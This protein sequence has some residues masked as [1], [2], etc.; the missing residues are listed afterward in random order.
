MTSVA[1]RPAPDPQIPPGGLT[2]G[3][4]AALCG[5][6]IDTLR[7]YEREGLTAEPADR[8][9]SGQRRYFA[10]D[11]SWLDGIVMLRGTGMPIRDIRAFTEICRREGS[12]AERLG[13]LE[14]H[15]ERVLEQLNETRSHLEAIERKIHFYRERKGSPSS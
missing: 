3:E 10:R 2:I 11:L 14:Q 5:L 4:A 8:A 7:Y 6:S 12:E 1:P 13:V 15:R 9:P